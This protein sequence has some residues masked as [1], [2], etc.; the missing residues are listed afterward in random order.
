MR[1][2]LKKLNLMSRISTTLAKNLKVVLNLMSRISTTLAKNLKV[3][4][5]SHFQS[6]IHKICQ[7]QMDFFGPCPPPFRFKICDSPFIPHVL[8]IVICLYLKRNKHVMCIFIYI[9]HLNILF[10]THHTYTKKHIKSG[11]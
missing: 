9:N 6:I 8:F 5:N 3:V 2:L 7:N 1:F 11:A 4:L 10:D